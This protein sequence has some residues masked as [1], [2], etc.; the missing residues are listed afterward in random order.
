M[1]Q[2]HDVWVITRANNRD[3]IESTRLD[4]V[5]RVH[6]IYY[7]LPGWLRFWKK[8][9]RGVQLYYYLWQIGAYFTV[10]RLL[11]TTPLDL[12]H[13][14]TF[15]KFWVPSWM[16]LLPIPLIFGP[17]GGGEDTPAQLL[18]GL[19][20]RQQRFEALR[21]LARGLFRY[22]PVLRRTLRKATVVAATKETAT[23]IEQ[24]FHPRH[25]I[26]IPQVGVSVTEMAKFDAI[27]PKTC[28]PFRLLSIGRLVHWKGYHLA[29]KAFAQFLKTYPNA[30]YWL[31]SSG[32]ER[33]ALETLAQSL[34]CGKQVK[35]LGRLPTLDAVYAKLEQAD[36][37]VHPALHEAFGNACLEAMAAG[38]PVI[39]LNEGG[40]GLQVTPETG[41]AVEPGT[42]E[43]TVDRLAQA[44][45]RLATTPG[46]AANMG[47]MARQRVREQFSWEE[48]AR[49]MNVV[50]KENAYSV[51]H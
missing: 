18:Q 43:E 47:R 34:G 24:Y 2:H 13:H 19:T 14:V 6:W 50:Y 7:D 36:A 41:I 48:M 31:V 25:A 5:Q 49:Q 3:L 1:S 32:P 44:M 30:E 27:A 17:V 20:P 23:V 45:T 15:G 9:G 35:F 33:E 16:G 28:G 26:I 42:E 29:I 10:R 8:G 40:P 4:W 39:C 12:V 51:Q 46:L 22:D 38:R 11:R 21:N 37:L